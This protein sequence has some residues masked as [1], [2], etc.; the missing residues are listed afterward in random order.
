MV[1]LIDDV[2]NYIKEFIFHDIK[3]HGKHLKDDKNIKKYNEIIKKLP[4]LIHKAE[5]A[6]IIYNSGKKDVR[7]IKFVYII[8]HKRVRRLIIEYQTFNSIYK[9]SE[10]KWGVKNL[11][12]ELHEKFRKEYY[13]N[14]KNKE[15]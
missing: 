11:S 14:I 13:E 10:R 1:Y 7:F 4:M 15:I 6:R 12:D 5:T 2:W 8:K 3:K 9:K